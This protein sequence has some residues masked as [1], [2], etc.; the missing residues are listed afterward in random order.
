MKLL[1]APW[2]NPSGWREVVYVF[3]GKSIK[4]C[5]SLRALQEVIE[6]D[7]TIIVGLD[8][9]AEKGENYQDVKE[10]AEGK[11]REHA[12]RFGLEGYEVLIAP[13]IG[14]FSNGTFHGGALDYYH[15]VTARLAL[16]LL[17]HVGET[18]SI[19][20][21]LTHGINYSTILT[22]KAV[23]EVAE[24]IS[25]FKETRFTAYNA[26]PSLP[27]A[28]GKLS[29]NIIEQST[30]TPTPLTERITQKRPLEPLNLSVDERRRLFEEELKEVREV[31]DLELSAFIGALYNGLPLALFRF[32]PEKGRLKEVILASLNLYERYVE[33]ESQGKL[34]VTRRVR[35]GNDLKVYVFAYMIA[36]LLSANGLIFSR[37]KE[38]AL[39]EVESLT[40]SLFKFD[41]RLKKRIETDIHTLKTDLE[42][43]E[44][45]DWQ[46][47]N[48]VIGRK[49]GGIDERNF[50][51]HS[52]FERNAVEVK[53]ESGMLLLRYHEDKIETVAK[54]CQKGLKREISLES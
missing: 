27:S 24:A 2:G 46:T 34:K 40:E 45:A 16:I 43:K 18:L 1:I 53:K 6:P 13:G 48:S 14:T 42:G 19:H 26:D 51:A 20:L 9:L 23:R 35:M 38:V 11:I 17:E 31:D 54:M 30:P 47:Y 32:Y 7:K 44:A 8:T 28:T 3:G 52:G 10:D 50:L 4:A 49:I 12:D 15:Y 22:Y 41:E 21:D 29:I 39:S 25:I 36:T 5:T 37:K 33:V